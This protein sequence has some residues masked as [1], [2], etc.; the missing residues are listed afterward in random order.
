MLG[1]ITDAVALLPMLIPGLGT[2]FWGITTTGLSYQ[3]AMGMGASLMAGWTVLLLWAFFLF[4]K[5]RGGPGVRS[6][7][8]TLMDKPG[9]EKDLPPG[10]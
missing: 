9:E 5:H 8:R 1:A 2:L 10:A 3:F 4:I 7:G 6:E